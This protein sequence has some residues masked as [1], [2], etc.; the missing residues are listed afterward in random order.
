MESRR[1]LAPL[2][3]LVVGCSGSSPGADAPPAVTDAAPDA[4]CGDGITAEPGLVVTT[5]GAV[6]GVADGGTWAFRGVPYAAAPVGDLR[7]KAPVP[8]AC[9]TGERD[10][11]QFPPP[12]V[13]RGELG[14]G[15]IT[16]DEDCLHVN[17][18]TPTAAAEPRPVLVFIHGGGNVSGSTTEEAQGVLLYDGRHLAERG[19]VVVVTLQYRLNIFGYLVHDAFAPESSSGMAGNYA[20]RDHIAALTWVRDNIAGFGGDP[21]RVMLFGESGGATDVCALYASPGA[22]GLFH[23]AIMQSGS[24]RGETYDDARDIGNDLAVAAGCD[25]SADVPGCLRDRSAADI[26][27]LV[28]TDVVVGEGRIKTPFG[29]T[30]DGALLPASPYDLIMQGAH[31]H[32][33][34]VVG[35]NED[36]MTHPVFG[37]PLMLTVEQYR[38]RVV[39]LVGAALAPS[40]LARYPAAAYP[41]PRAALVALM[42][43]VQFV[44]PARLYARAAAAAQDEPVYRYFFTHAL[45]G[46]QA[47]FGAMHGLELPFIFQKIDLYGSYDPTPGDLALQD[48][49]GGYWTRF[50]ATRDPNGASAPAWPVYD[51]ATDSYLE[52]AGV[53]AAGTGVRTAQCDFWDSLVL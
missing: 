5:S 29:P 9:W 2:V 20:V 6:R 27:G 35:A 17:V 38:A 43:D 11:S 37:I 18:W 45:S 24:C 40:V 36:E 42:G 8:H 50:A 4:A 46:P 32:V 26:L 10:A 49:A 28:D 16:G 48:L 25:G 13:Q 39:A 47:A 14:T 19:D 31:N 15:T 12:C 1:L 3:L 52:L 51:P 23:A 30:I 44:C 21:A 22:A 41:T 33:P 53:S 7:W 34:F